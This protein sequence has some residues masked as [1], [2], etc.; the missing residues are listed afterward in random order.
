MKNYFN[1]TEKAIDSPFFM[2]KIKTGL[3]ETIQSRYEHLR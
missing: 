3:Y 1:F 2:Y